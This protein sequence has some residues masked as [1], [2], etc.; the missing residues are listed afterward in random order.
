MSRRKN[1]KGIN[2]HN[3]RWQDLPLW[4]LFVCL[5]YW[6]EK[7]VMPV[8]L[9][10]MLQ[11]GVKHN[12]EFSVSIIKGLWKT[13]FRSRMTYSTMKGVFGDLEKW[14]LLGRWITA[15]VISCLP[16]SSQE[17]NTFGFYNIMMQI[18]LFYSFL[19]KC[20][21]RLWQVA[22]KGRGPLCS[23]DYAVLLV[24]LSLPPPPSTWIPSFSAPPH[25]F[26]FFFFFLLRWMR[27]TEKAV[28]D[29]CLLGIFLEPI[30]WMM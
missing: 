7:D 23:G 27:H 30:K 29:F 21:G 20:T 28:V 25:C 19:F 2:L 3:G 17:S 10:G 26:F 12:Q 14:R 6:R 5:F 18:I 13:R 22:M 15:H 9:A 16:F 1:S 4:Q 24:K 11:N 8:C